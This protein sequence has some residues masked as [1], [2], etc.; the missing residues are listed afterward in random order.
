MVNAEMLTARMRAIRFVNEAVTL[1]V[2][3]A[4]T[5]CVS[6]AVTLFVNIRL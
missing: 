4:V 6:E 5:L 3:E 2:S 1:C